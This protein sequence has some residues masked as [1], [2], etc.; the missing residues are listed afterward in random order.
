MLKAS[1]GDRG[2]V[3][4]KVNLRD[5]FWVSDESFARGGLNRV[6]QKHVDFLVCDSDSM[7]PR[8]AVELDDASHLL[9]SSRASDEVKN[10]AFASA[11][12]PLVRIRFRWSY[13]VAE[14]RNEIAAQVASLV[15]SR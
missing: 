8:F 4:V 15:A 11:R 10:E 14:V 2:V 6:S 12:L 5:L 13:D 7:V 1:V 9:A 3:F